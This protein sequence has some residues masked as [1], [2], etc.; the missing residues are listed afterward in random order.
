MNERELNKLMNYDNKK[1]YFKKRLIIGLA[2]LPISVV[3][4]GFVIKYGWNNILSTIDGVPSINL[5]QAIAIDVLVSFV[6]AKKRA[7]GDFAAEVG[8]A[9]ISPLMTLLL[10]LIVTLFM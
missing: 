5:P 9:F 4:S 8:R 1:S 6:V 2:L 10:F 3:W 7:E